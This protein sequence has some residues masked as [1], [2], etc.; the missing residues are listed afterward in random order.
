M[1]FNDASKK[2]PVS[3]REVL[4]WN[5]DRGYFIG[6]YLQFRGWAAVSKDHGPVSVYP[7]YWTELPN[8]PSKHVEGVS[9]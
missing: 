1:T 7:V 9:S 5:E 3:A 4:C 2:T 6:K 8:D